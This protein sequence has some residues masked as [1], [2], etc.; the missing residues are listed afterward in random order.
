M[1]GFAAILCLL[2]SFDL[3]AR[4][5][6]QFEGVFS[7]PP[8]DTG[9]RLLKRSPA[10]ATDRGTSPYGGNS[11]MLRALMGDRTFYNCY[12]DL[13]LTHT[14][15]PDHPLV[16][17]DGK[18][19][20]FGTTFSPNRIEFA[21][22]GGAEPSRVILNQNYSRGWR[23]TLGPVTIDPQYR[24]PAVIL[25]RG[26]AGKFAFVFVPP[27]LALGVSLLALAIVGSAFAWKRVMPER[28]AG[29]SRRRLA[30][31]P[32]HGLLS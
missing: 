3:V 24:R 25:E 5:R 1:K 6:T 29:A 16:F 18:S 26:Q 17:T 10:L 11:P 19:N 14:A 28:A 4:N 27:G 21:V 8:L 30:A 32:V 23:S 15:D 31:D 12:E 2:A 7:L 22:V 9:F 13:Q 20:M